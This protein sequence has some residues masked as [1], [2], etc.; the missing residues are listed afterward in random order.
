MPRKKNIPDDLPTYL[1]LGEAAVRYGLSEMSLTNLV[2]GGTIEAA[3]N[4]S[5][6]VFVNE[7]D[8]QAEKDRQETI[9]TKDEVIEERW[10]ELRGQGITLTDAAEKYEISRTTIF[11]W[12]RNYG[13]ITILKEGYAM[14]IDEAEMAYCADIYHRRKKAGIGHYGAPLL[15]EEGREYQLKHE[16]LA[17]YRKRKR[18]RRSSGG[19]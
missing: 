3:K 19:V 17:E 16:W 13:Y 11:E 6:E 1:P 10:P 8:V 18:R 14:E 2:A 15:D 5:G 9:P 12:V 4:Q 7:S